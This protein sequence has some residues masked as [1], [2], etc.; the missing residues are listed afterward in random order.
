MIAF[1]I[2]GAL[3]KVYNYSIPAFLLAIILSPLMESNFLRTLNI[4][5]TKLFFESTI[6]QIMLGL[7]VVSA[8]AP[9]LI[10][11]RK[12]RSHSLLPVEK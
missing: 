7:I 2:L 8:L 9:A 1:G 4:G 6:S 11:L 12:R 5:G 3:F 10:I